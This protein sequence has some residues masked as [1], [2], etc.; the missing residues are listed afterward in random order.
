MA[1]VEAKDIP[2]MQQFMQPFW[3][4]I[5]KFYKPEDNDEYWNELSAYSNELAEKF[6]EELA[7]ILILVVADYFDN[8]YHKRK[9]PVWK[10]LDELWKN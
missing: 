7:Q 1:S 4:F 3:T 6:P 9:F 2:V 5:K 8:K 10:R